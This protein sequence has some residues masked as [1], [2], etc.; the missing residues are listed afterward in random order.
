MCV[1]VVF[2]R[3]VYKYHAMDSVVDLIKTENG[4]VIF[5]PPVSR[6]RSVAGVSGVWEPGED[7]DG[8]RPHPPEGRGTR[9]GSGARHHC[10]LPSCVCI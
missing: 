6:F 8:V 5:L 3:I 1:S 7:G 9:D 2:S 4:I 10:R